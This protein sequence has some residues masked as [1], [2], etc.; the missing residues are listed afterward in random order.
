MDSD[1]EIRKIFKPYDKD[2]TG[3]IKREDMK[4]ILL[5]L[6]VQFTEEEMEAVLTEGD[7]EGVG[8]V[9]YIVV[10]KILKFGRY[11]LDPLD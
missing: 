9:D 3:T 7:L 2:G 10:F 6:G 4:K 1:Q 11:V 5:N 8:E